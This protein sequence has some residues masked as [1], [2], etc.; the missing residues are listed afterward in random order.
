MGKGKRIDNQNSSTLT[1]S[2]SRAFGRVCGFVKENKRLSIIA[3]AGFLAVTLYLLAV[4]S[5]MG[6]TPEPGPPEFYEHTPTPEP[7]PEPTPEPEPE[8][9]LFDYTNPLTG[10]PFSNDEKLGYR[11]PIAVMYNNIHG[12]GGRN[13]ALPMWGIGRADIIYEVMVEGSTSRM[14]AF[15]QDFEDIP[16]IGSIRSARTYFLELALAYDAV[17]VHDGQSPAAWS[18]MRAWGMDRIDGYTSPTPFRRD[19]S[20]RPNVSNEHTQFSSGDRLMMPF[21]KFSRLEMDRHFSNGLYFSENARPIGSK[22]EN[23]TVPLSGS[24]RTVFDLKDSGLYGVS[25]YNAPFIDGQDGEQVT[26]T[27]LLIIQTSISGVPG[28]RD[29][30]LNV[31]LQSGGSGFYAAGGQYI[32]IKWERDGHNTP[33]RYFTAAGE[34]L[35]MLP[36][37]TYVCVIPTGQ[38]PEFE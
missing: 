35:Q 9:I 25:Q 8:P 21:E 24:K 26:V 29:G 36:G 4:L 30:R 5:M 11:R 19:K 12:P 3:V 16:K 31:S 6:G 37:K 17:L 14:L 33:F 22:A 32:P 20:D 7:G 13:H 1:K 38:I 34:P 23:V 10:L 18:E 28:D 2:I 15:F 27:N